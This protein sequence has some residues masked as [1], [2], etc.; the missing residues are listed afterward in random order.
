MSPLATLQT[1]MTPETYQAIESIFEQFD[2][3]VATLENA[4]LMGDSEFDPARSGE[5][6]LSRCSTC[7]HCAA[8]A[9]TLSSTTATPSTVVGPTNDP[10]AILWQTK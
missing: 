8:T 10:A 3:R 9:T 6:E 7:T 2:Q 1:G 5:R 4:I